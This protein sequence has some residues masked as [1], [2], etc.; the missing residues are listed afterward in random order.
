MGFHPRIAIRFHP[1]IPAP[2]NRALIER[3]AKDRFNDFNL[4]SR[5]SRAPPSDFSLAL[6]LA[7]GGPPLVTAPGVRADERAQPRSP[8]REASGSGTIRPIHPGLG[9]YDH[10]VRA[11]F[12]A[13]SCLSAALALGG[14]SDGTG[15][16][17]DS[18]PSPP[19]SQVVPQGL[20]AKSGTPA[21]CSALATDQA[22]IQ[23]VDVLREVVVDGRSSDTMAASAARLRTYVTSFPSAV[24]AADSLVR[25]SRTPEDPAATDAVVTA[26]RTLDGEVQAQCDFPLS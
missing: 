17:S 1:G 16:S 19:S 14:C 12:V 11:A 25:L 18:K 26:F 10:R 9:G 4:A 15:G 24:G 21:V 6:R 2:P 22:I 23:M 13:A 8:G 3:T 7:H 20:V 5:V